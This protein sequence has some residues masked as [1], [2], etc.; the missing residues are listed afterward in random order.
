MMDDFFLF[1]ID[2]VVFLSGL[3]EDEVKQEGPD[4]C[5]TLE[6]KAT[7]KKKKVKRGGE[8]KVV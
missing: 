1:S 3:S 2:R 4:T 8:E 7:A 6:A 5:R